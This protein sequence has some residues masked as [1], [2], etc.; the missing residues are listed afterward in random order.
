M[1]IGDL[2]TLLYETV[3]YYIII[4][5]AGRQGEFGEKQYLLQPIVGGPEKKARY[6]DIRTV[7]KIDRCKN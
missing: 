2:V 6:S 7:C 5:D 1:K 3:K 4:G